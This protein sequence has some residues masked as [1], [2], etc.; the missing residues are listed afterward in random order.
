MR[1]NFI[2]TAVITVLMIM[3]GCGEKA[4]NDTP[5]DIIDYGINHDA[6][7]LSQI[8]SE[9]VDSVKTNIK[10]HYSHTSHGEQLSYGVELI[11]QSDAQY[12]V[13]IGYS[14][15]PT[16][17]GALCIFDGQEGETYITPD[18]YWESGDGMNYTRA[19]LT[20]NPSINVSMWCWCTQCDYYDQGQ[21]QVYLD[22][23]DALE[24][25]FP[26]VTFV[27]FTGN[28]QSSGDDGYNRFQRNQQ[29]RQHCRDNSKLLFDFAELDGYW[30][31]T[32]QQVW[33]A[34]TYEHNGIN[35]PLEHPEFNGD[36]HGHT[37]DA[38]CNQKGQAL[39]WL[40]ATIA[41][42]DGN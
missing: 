37:T 36:E 35:I 22:S 25:E 34:S 13:A 24:T 23:M 14:E 7:D 6:C 31:D 2:M 32:D 29:I 5:P 8:P 11:E 18:L 16:E 10:V 9:W 12:S 40:L 27:Y 42:W 17:A 21:V 19:A 33:Q 20:N 4:V 28:A 30:Y 15:L 1:R 3:A 38:S 39:W 26:N 41:G